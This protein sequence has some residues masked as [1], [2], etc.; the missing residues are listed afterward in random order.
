MIWYLGYGTK[1][2]IKPVCNNN[3][4]ASAKIVVSHYC[5][6]N[7]VTCDLSTQ[8]ASFASVTRIEL[9]NTKLTGT[10][11]TSIGYLSYLQYLSLGRNIIS[12][13]IPT[14]LGSMTGMI[15]L[16][17]NGN[18]IIGT[19]PTNIGSLL[20][21]TKLSLQFNKLIGTIP[22]T[23]GSMTSLQ[24]VLLNNNLLTGTVPSTISHLIALSSLH[25]NNNYLSMGNSI[26]TIP[27]T[28]FSPATLLG[29]DLNMTSNCI[30]FEYN[31]LKTIPTN[32]KN[33]KSTIIFFSIFC[34]IFCSI[35][36][37]QYFYFLQYSILFHLFFLLSFIL[38]GPVFH[39]ILFIFISFYSI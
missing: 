30:R 9:E 21:L 1:T 34:S 35:C 3:E 19:I 13:T 15:S 7:G 37:A 22:I 32:C 6:F 4:S 14:V 26:D 12:G 38:R 33:G 27:S 31:G 20:S 16:S 23:L 10:I 28:Y 5:S 18:N 25:L 17:L 24:T 36:F 29:N 8:S 2:W 11:P 39:M